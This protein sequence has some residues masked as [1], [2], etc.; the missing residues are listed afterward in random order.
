MSAGRAAA[1]EAMR[2]LILVA[3]DNPLNIRVISQ[4]LERCACDVVSVVNGRECVDFVSGMMHGQNPVRRSR[5]T[6]ILMDLHMPVMDGLEATRAIRLLEA[7]APPLLWP[8]VHIIALTADDPG[9]VG[10]ACRDAG[11]S[12]FLRKPVVMVDLRR[13]LQ[14][15]GVSMPA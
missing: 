6:A 14:S 8:P 9:E 15:A 12:A 1:D 7:A 11:M 3:D 10:D 2:P 4:Q 5:L 13:L